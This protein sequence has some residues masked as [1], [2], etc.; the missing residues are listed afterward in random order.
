MISKW[1]E[2]IHLAEIGSPGWTRKN[3]KDSMSVFCEIYK[4]RPINDN[5]GGMKAPHAFAIWFILR[6]LKPKF[7]I[8]SGVFKG[9]GTWLFEKASPSSK[10]Y[11]IDI[12]L[13]Q[14]VYISKNVTYF[15]KDFSALNWGQIDKE[16]TLVFFDD[17]Q[18]AIDRIKF[19]KKEGFK[20]LVFEDNYPTGQGDC[21]SLKQA[22]DRGNID[23]QF[24][25]RELKVYYEM[26]PIFKSKMTRWG[27]DWVD[28]RYPTP[29]ALFAQVESEYLQLFYNEAMN[30]TWMC[31]VELK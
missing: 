28:K 22:F 29:E 27:D 3:I 6:F 20:A 1:P 5:V 17:H 10:I 31:Y 21:Y 13:S 12:N 11:S 18:N 4:Q 8:E 2:N 16:K 9:Q 30:Y 7:I 15:S 26:P 24:L 14:R 19:C 23:A 25:K